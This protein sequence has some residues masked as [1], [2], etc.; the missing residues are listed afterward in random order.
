MFVIDFLTDFFVKFEY[1]REQIFYSVFI[2][3]SM[4]K[5]QSCKLKGH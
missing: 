2:D 1:L 4:L 5:A 3:H